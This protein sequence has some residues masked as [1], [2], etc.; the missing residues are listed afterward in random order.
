MDYQA[1]HLFAFNKKIS[2]STRLHSMDC[3]NFT[4]L[5]SQPG[6]YSYISNPWKLDYEGV[7][8]VKTA[9]SSSML[10]TTLNSY[11]LPSIF[12]Y[13][14]KLQ[15]TTLYLCTKIGLPNQSC[16]GKMIR[17]KNLSKWRI[18]WKINLSICVFHVDSKLHQK[19]G[20][21]MGFIAK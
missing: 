18:S 19:N 17:L 12:L 2:I 6:L 1:I 8:K 4:K 10:A 9:T 3:S 16:G 20:K 15:M 7:V 21:N 5:L 11:S 14:S 13:R